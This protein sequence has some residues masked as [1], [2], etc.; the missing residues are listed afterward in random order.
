LE[1][2][3]TAVLSTIG[4]QQNREI[5][6]G[7]IKY[8]RLADFL[9]GLTF[10]NAE[11]VTK[12]KCS[13]EELL[14]ELG[15]VSVVQIPESKRRYG[16]TALLKNDGTFYEMRFPEEFLNRISIDWQAFIQLSEESR[17]VI[18]E[19]LSNM[20]NM[21]PSLVRHRDVPFEEY[22]KED[23]AKSVSLEEFLVDIDSNSEKQ[24]VTS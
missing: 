4:N 7:V 2:L 10:Q 11:L 24:A 3:K 17:A 6:R 19:A 13:F 22:F 18:L 8:R 9:N 21:G 15:I 16:N 12:K 23:N 20:R 5:A 14:Q 1:E